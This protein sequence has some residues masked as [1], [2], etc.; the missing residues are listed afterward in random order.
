MYKEKLIENDVISATL[1]D[2]AL[3]AVRHNKQ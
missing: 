2:E 3:Q 1:V